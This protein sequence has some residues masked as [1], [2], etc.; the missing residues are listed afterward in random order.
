MNRTANDIVMDGVAHHLRDVEAESRG[1]YA[2]A[3]RVSRIVRGA[4]REGLRQ[5]DPDHSAPFYVLAAL[6]EAGRLV[7]KDDVGLLPAALDVIDAV[8]Q[9]GPYTPRRV[10]RALQAFDALVEDRQ[11]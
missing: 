3:D 4:I 6:R 11:P 1:S 2:T 9:W 7:P 10:T 8:R 5:P